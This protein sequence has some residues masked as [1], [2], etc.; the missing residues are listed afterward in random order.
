MILNDT[1]RGTKPNVTE[2]T[3]TLISEPLVENRQLTFLH[4]MIRDSIRMCANDEYIGNPL[5][6]LGILWEIMNFSK[7]EVHQPKDSDFIDVMYTFD[8]P[9]VHVSDSL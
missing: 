7:R 6:V 4:S 8:V 3:L 2:K 5:R 1:G 9:R